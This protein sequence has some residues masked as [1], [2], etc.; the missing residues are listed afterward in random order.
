MYVS[1]CSLKQNFS[2]PD[3]TSITLMYCVSAMNPLF[4]I[5]HLINLK[6][7]VNE[8]W[9]TNC[10]LKVSCRFLCL[11]SDPFTHLHHGY[12]CNPWIPDI[13]TPSFPPSS[14]SHFI[15]Y[16]L[17]SGTRGIVTSHFIFI[18]DSSKKYKFPQ[19]L[20][21]MNIIWRKTPLVMSRSDRYCQIWFLFKNP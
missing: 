7:G 10:M 17:K 14:V 8:R 19:F 3:Y 16:K 12:L 11:L 4:A 6:P 21:T 2:S 1:S 5:N 20:Y 15:C 13:S 9:N 18:I